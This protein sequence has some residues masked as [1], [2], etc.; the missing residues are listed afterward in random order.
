MHRQMG[1][2]RGTW[3][4]H[5]VCVRYLGGCKEL[6]LGRHSLRSSSHS[7]SGPPRACPGP[8]P[9]SHS[10]GAPMVAFPQSQLG[11]APQPWARTL[12]WLSP[13]P[14]SG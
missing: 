5:A 1:V 11:G 3:A 2:G 7:I 14:A 9:G 10:T 8:H 6:E 4:L 12:L 13:I